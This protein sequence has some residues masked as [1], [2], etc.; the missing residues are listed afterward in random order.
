MKRLVIASQKGGVGKTTV[1]LNLAYAFAAR[2]YRTL[3]VDTDPQG[4][5]GL[6]LARKGERFPGFVDC[7]RGEAALEAAAVRT[8]QEKLSL[9]LFGAVSMREVDELAARVA[10]P[11]ALDAL[12]A[13]SEDRYD[14]VVFDTP[15]GLGG[16]TGG[17]MRV[18]THVLSPLQ[19][20][21]LAFRSV[22]QLLEVIAAL[23]AEGADV[24][25][26]GLLLTM[27]QT[28]DR[29]SLG[30]AQEVWMNF[31]PEFVLKTTLPRD[32]TILAAGAGGVPVAL[33]SKK[34]PPIAGIFD[35]LVLELEPK[36]GLVMESV[37][38]EP[39]DLLVP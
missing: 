9:L 39:L 7:L 6:S 28:R 33:L 20:E 3:L 31:P 27:L 13:E 1:S 24:E 15:S 37:D 32:A 25:L 35:Q 17:V 22:H 26:A 14:M 4:A 38:D 21:P 19:A 5:V 16:V 30:V 23:K 12:L 18:A 11:G 2:G 36:L 29:A 34:A 8:R 10:T